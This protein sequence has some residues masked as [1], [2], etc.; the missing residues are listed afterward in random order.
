MRLL[1][2]AVC[3]AAMLG[4]AD[5]ISAGAAKDHLNQT[6]T[7]CGKVVGTRYLDQSAPKITFLNFD[8]PY[9]DSP[10]TAIVPGDNRAK[11][12]EP[13]K[14]YLEKNLC[15][16]GKIEEYNKKPQ[17]VLTDPSQVRVEGK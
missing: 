4:A 5:K 14:V 9:P 8:K 13:E 10:F 6:A 12:G 16:T 17:I 3:F 15:V 7:V 2:F 11:F 1:L